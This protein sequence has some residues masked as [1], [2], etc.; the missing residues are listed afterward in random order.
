M[1]C[2]LKPWKA[3]RE[4]TSMKDSFV[5]LT[6][7]ETPLLEGKYYFTLSYKLC[8]AAFQLIECLIN[9]NCG[10]FFSLVFK[11][12]S[13]QYIPFLYFL[14]SVSRVWVP[15]SGTWLSHSESTRQARETGTTSGLFTNTLLLTQTGSSW[16]ML[17]RHSIQTASD[18]GIKS[19]LDLQLM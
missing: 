3:V 9:W 18:P 2:S 17:L 10:T 13:D 6:N 5:C 7:W 11:T 1:T 19:Y 15:T 12:R 14:S 4:K 16:W 8:F